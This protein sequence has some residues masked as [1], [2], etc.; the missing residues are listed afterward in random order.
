MSLK[1]NWNGHLELIIPPRPVIKP[2]I[3]AFVFCHRISAL[4]LSTS[5]PSPF[6]YGAAALRRIQTYNTITALS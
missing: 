4:T 1:F 2:D 3:P 6:K 5:S